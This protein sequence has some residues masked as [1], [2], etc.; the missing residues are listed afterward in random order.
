MSEHVNR[1]VSSKMSNQTKF[2]RL[3]KIKKKE[4]IDVLKKKISFSINLFTFTILLFI[5]IVISSYLR[6]SHLLT[7]VRFIH[8]LFCTQSVFFF[9]ITNQHL[10]VAVVDFGA[11]ISHLPI[12][13]NRIDHFRNYTATSCMSLKKKKK[14]IPLTING[15]RF[16]MFSNICSAGDRRKHVKRL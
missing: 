7:S 5:N 12:Y 2:H 4:A 6:Y 9:I 10:S 1:L 16:P 11:H 8:H 3:N 14:L 13:G 15:N